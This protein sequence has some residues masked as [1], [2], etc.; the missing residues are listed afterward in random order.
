VQRPRETGSSSRARRHERTKALY[1][2]LADPEADIRSRADILAEIVTLNMGLADS[3]AHRFRSRGIEEDD[4]KQVAYLALFRAAGKFDPTA[5]ND[6][7]AY[8]VPT[9]TGEIRKHFRD[10]GWMVRP[11]RRLQELQSRIN[12][13]KS[14]LAHSTGRTPRPSELAAHLDVPIDDLIEALACDGCF[15][16]SSLDRPVGMDDVGTLGDLLISEGDADA[17]YG[18]SAAEARAMLG[19]LV[20]ELGERDRLVLQRRFFEGRTQREIGEELGVTQMQVSRILGRILERLRQQLG[21]SD[22]AA[23]RL[24][25]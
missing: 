18:Q 10:H 9:M 5:D 17:G 7:L 16:P 21:D 14:E 23:V 22:R 12:A 25:G 2:L 15:N 20:R 6:F 8:A 24:A 4:L 3:I 13:A 11:P 19:P 1:A